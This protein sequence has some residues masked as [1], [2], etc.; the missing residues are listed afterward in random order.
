MCHVYARCAC[1]QN[2]KSYRLPI[3]V[4]DNVIR[5]VN[6]HPVKVDACER[7]RVRSAV[8]DRRHATTGAA[9]VRPEINDSSSVGIDLHSGR[10][11]DKGG[12]N[13]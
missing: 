1:I 8:E 13:I 6:I 10:R 5:V 3:D 7:A 11:K 4:L 9:P 2:W 12:E